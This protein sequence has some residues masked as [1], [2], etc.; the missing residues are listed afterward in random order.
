MQSINQSKYYLLFLVFVLVQ[1]PRHGG[2]E[3]T[4]LDVER[5]RGRPLSKYERNMMI[6]DWLHTLDEGDT[7]CPPDIAVT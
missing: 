1:V 5:E 7:L 3:L 6:F 2:R 4:L